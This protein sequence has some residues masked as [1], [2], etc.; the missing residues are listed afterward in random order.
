MYVVLVSVV[1]G[2]NVFLLLFLYTLGV[3]QNCRIVKSLDCR[4]KTA[5]ILPS[6]WLETTKFLAL[7]ISLRIFVLPNLRNCEM[8][9]FVEVIRLVEVGELGAFVRCAV[10]VELDSKPR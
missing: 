3:L 9:G 2:T 4:A 1:S 8:T 6:A 10:R 5:N 7:V